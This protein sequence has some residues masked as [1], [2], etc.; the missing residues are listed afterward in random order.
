MVIFIFSPF[1]ANVILIN[2]ILT[3]FTLYLIIIN[4]S[5]LLIYFNNLTF[6]YLFTTPILCLIITLIELVLIF[7][8]VF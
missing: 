4:N 7:F 5:F 2:D 8:P 6:I 1:N 3:P